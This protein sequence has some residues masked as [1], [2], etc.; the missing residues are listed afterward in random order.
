LDRRTV[1]VGLSGR[2]LAASRAV[3]AQPAGKILRVGVLW[4]GGNAEEEA[5]FLGAVREGFTQLGYVEGKNIALLN[6]FAGEEYERFHRNAAELVSS[7]VDV[8]VAVTQPAAVAAQ[9]STKT[10]PIVF[11][12][13]P[14]PVGIKLVE[15][16][17]RPGGNIT[18]LTNVAGDI[19]AKRIQIFKEAV[20]GLS[21]VAVLVNATDPEGA[22]RYI[23]EIEPAA[24]RLGV[25]VRSVDIR[26]PADLDRAFGMMAQEKIQGVVGTPEG[27]FYVKRS[28]IAQL[29]L[30]HRLPTIGT[31]P[32]QTEAGWLMGYGANVKAIF[33]RTAY[34][35]DKIL[36]GAR[37]GDLP[38]EQ[39]TTFELVVN[40]KTAKVLG[41]TIPPSVLQRADQVIE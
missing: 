11:V 34:Y 16:L 25:S 40:L 1:I 9:R 35:V 37:P 27:I 20:A 41:L 6:T 38:V 12:S 24:R 15:S 29:A 22:S 21:R 33:R 10:L 2:L 26:V 17:A 3:E 4:H 8:I 32:E 39:P 18:G 23:R 19:S 7:N 28:Q 30:T 13:V 36:K 5:N 14:D 31:T